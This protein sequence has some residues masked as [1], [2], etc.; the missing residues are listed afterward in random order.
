MILK[1]I[2]MAAAAMLVMVHDPLKDLNMGDAAP[3]L[4][5]SMMDVSGKETTLK[6]IAGEKGLLVIFTSNQCPFVV[7]SE[8]SEGWDGRYGDL[9]AFSKR[10]GVGM[11]LI[12]SN[13]ATR[14]KGESLYDMKKRYKDKGYGGHYLLDENSV[15]A[16]AYAA[17]TTPHVFLFDKDMKLVYKGA[18]DDNVADAS[19]VK[20]HWLKNAMANLGAGKPIDPATTRNI[21][22]SIKRV[23][24]PHDH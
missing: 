9:A 5:R 4:D 7:G 16:D 17:R 11:A 1:S 15:V 19:A 23:A 24:V 3:Q 8:G 18:I 2:A 12:N 14:E 13:H 22:C 21:G 20:E 10:I 6:A